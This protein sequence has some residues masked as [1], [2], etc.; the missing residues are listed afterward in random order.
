MTKLGILPDL[1]IFNGLRMVILVGYEWDK[2]ELFNKLSWRRQEELLATTEYSRHV[3][4]VH[5]FGVAW[6]YYHVAG[7]LYSYPRAFP[8]DNKCS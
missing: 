8:I 7:K 5:N 6:P 4:K 3:C 1:S 2:V